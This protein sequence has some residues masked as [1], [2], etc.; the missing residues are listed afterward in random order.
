MKQLL[1]LSLFGCLLAPVAQAQNPFVVLNTFSALKSASAN[2][3]ARQQNPQDYT[4]PVIYEGE[5][6]HCKRT[7]GAANLRKGGAQLVALEQLLAGRY[8]ALLADTVGI[9]TPAWETQYADALSQVQRALPTWSTLAYE[10]EVAFY[11][12]EDAGRRQWLQEVQAARQ[13]RARRA[14]RR[15]SLARLGAPLPPAAATKSE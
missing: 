10:E 6:F 7:P 9:L 3:R 14:A 13:Q 12:R 8:A 15:D 4:K 5:M 11:R 2:A 1:L